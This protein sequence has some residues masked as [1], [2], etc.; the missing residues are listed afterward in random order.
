MTNMLSLFTTCKPFEGITGIHQRN[1]IRSW[2]KLGLTPH[3]IGDEPGTHEIAQET[4]AIH[5]TEVDRNEDK[6]PRV[7]SLFVT[8]AQHTKTPYLAYLNSDIMLTPDFNKAIEQ[9]ARLPNK[10]KYLLIARRRNVP[11]SKAWDF[12]STNYAADLKKLDIENGSWDYPYAIDLFIYSKGLFEDIPP[13]SIG[14]PMWD[15]WMLW[16]AEKAGAIIIDVSEHVNILHP[17]HG[18]EGGW[19]DVTHGSSAQ[20]N[21]QLGPART[22]DIEGTATHYISSNNQL[23]KLT[24]EE[25]TTRQK[26]FRPDTEKELAAFLEHLAISSSADE[27]KLMDDLKAMMWRWQRFFPLQHEMQPDPEHLPD[28]VERMKALCFENESEAALLA[29]QTYFSQKIRD[30]AEKAHLEGREVYI[31]GAGQYGQRLFSLA[32]KLG[33]H[34]DA[35]IDQNHAAFSKKA[36]AAPVKSPDELKQNDTHSPY[37]LIGTMY[38]KDVIAKLKSMGFAEDSYAY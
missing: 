7:N 33:L 8:A 12:S 27:T 17:I 10:S 24:E 37:F 26:K 29:A 16:K 14:R 25:K 11:L 6:L 36:L 9:L 13:F 28:L 18:Y 4:N 20:Q 21:R 31:W 3:I 15:N 22:N 5:L 23:I 19:A 35:F 38:F 34:I 2:A 30:A 1:A 32:E